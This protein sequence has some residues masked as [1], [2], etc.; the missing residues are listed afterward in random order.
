MKI[1]TAEDLAAAKNISFAPDQL[2]E[3]EIGCEIWDVT[4]KV[5]EN[6]LGGVMSRWPNG[7]GAFSADGGQSNWGEWKSQ[8]ECSEYDEECLLLDVEEQ[9]WKAIWVDDRGVEWVEVRYNEEFD[10]EEDEKNFWWNLKEVYP[11]IQAKLASC[12]KAMVT[13]EQW[14]AIQQIDGWD[15]G[16][17]HAPNPIRLI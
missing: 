9:D 8:P 16:P 7:R 17:E 14:D 1:E 3:L 2:E 11:A 5:G 13:V 15:D 10:N 6:W 4:F 12:G